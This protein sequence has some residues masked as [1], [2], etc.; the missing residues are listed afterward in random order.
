[1]MS[2]AEDEVDVEGT[3][4][5]VTNTST[6]KLSVMYITAFLVTGC[7]ECFLWLQRRDWAYGSFWSW[8]CMHKPFFT[9][10]EA[11]MCFVYYKGSCY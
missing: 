3:V 6:G 8:L 10:S 2:Y 1:M 4:N 5:G 9:L 11:A 7:G